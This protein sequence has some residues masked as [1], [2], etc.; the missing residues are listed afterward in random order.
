M[1]RSQ[2]EHLLRAAGAIIE[3]SD[4]IIVGSQAILGQYPNAPL[5]MLTSMEADMVAANHP[6][7]TEVLN[8]IGDLS[9]FHDTFGYYVDPVSESTA[10]LPQGWRDRLVSVASPSTNGVTGHCLHPHD[11]MI[12]KIAA[13]REKDL[14]FAKL[15]VVHKMVDREEVLK[16]AMT[17]AATVE[18]P[19]RP[20]RV[21]ARLRRLFDE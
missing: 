11:L 3:E 6:D 10:I 4:F 15:M 1:N 17:I 14:D 7:R 5:A 18:D 8:V 9:N 13:G 19:E 21:T 2:L 20:R 16:L 12:S